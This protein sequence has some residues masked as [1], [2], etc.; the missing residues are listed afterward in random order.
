[1][2]ERQIQRAKTSRRVYRIEKGDDAGQIEKDASVVTTGDVPFSGN[3][4]DVRAVLNKTRQRSS[5][6]FSC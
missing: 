2:H 1:M 4:S 3:T 6:N 5:M